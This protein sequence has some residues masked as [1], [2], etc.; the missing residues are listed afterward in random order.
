MREQPSKGR[1]K[2]KDN[3]GCDDDGAQ[4]PFEKKSQAVR[5]RTYVAESKQSRSYSTCDGWLCFRA[6]QHI[7]LVIKLCP[8]GIICNPRR[9]GRLRSCDYTTPQHFASVKR[10]RLVTLGRTN[11]L[12][13]A[14]VVADH[15][16]PQV[17]VI[18]QLECLSVFR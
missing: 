13:S 16:V 4:A 11:M 10:T 17:V 7:E 6:R 3:I 12:P 1:S 8:F 14:V 18:D 15:I 5:Y 2:E 9:L